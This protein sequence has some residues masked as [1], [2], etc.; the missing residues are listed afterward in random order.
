MTSADRWE[1]VYRNGFGLGLLIV[2]F[3][4][5]T[6]IRSV[7]DDFAV[8]IW[9]QLLGD[10]E[11]DPAVY[12]KTETLIAFAVVLING[13]AITIK[14]NRAALLGSLV[15][16]AAGFVIV[17]AS[18]YGHSAGVL[19]PF[20]FMVLVGLGMY[21]PYV[22]FHT[23]VFERLIAS[24]QQTANVGYLMYL[25]DATGYL[26]YVGVLVFR[27]VTTNDINMLELFTG[28]ALGISVCS[29]ILTAVLIFY[30]SRTLAPVGVTT[31]SS[32][33]TR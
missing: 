30:F 4:L 24:V 23:T 25:A 16:M 29:L 12:S 22:A 3:I 10:A 19:P 1:F 21:I 31:D 26:G 32:T 27:N 9:D 8:E 7:R 14:G 13:L 15:L 2:I 5:L 6:I 18:L 20:P 33:A 17:L 11:E 28:L